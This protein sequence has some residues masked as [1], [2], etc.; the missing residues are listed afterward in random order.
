MRRV[1][2]TVDIVRF[3]LGSYTDFPLRLR[4][5]VVILYA[6]KDGAESQRFTPVWNLSRLG[7]HGKSSD[8]W[9]TGNSEVCVHFV[10]CPH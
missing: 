1:V 7:F 3:T 6:L 2:I 9:P 4:S 8:E 10:C 5:P